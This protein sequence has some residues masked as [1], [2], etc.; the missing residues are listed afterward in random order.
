MI[1]K[2]SLSVLLLCASLAPAQAGLFDS[3]P[4]KPALSDET[5]AQIQ[6]AFDDQR[7]L[8][9]SKILDQALL[10]SG[11]DP[12]LT[13]WAGKLSLVHGRYQDALTNF[14][15]IKM[16]T[17][18]RA[19]ALEGE[20]I[21]LMQ[22]GRLDEALFSLQ[23]AVMANP[24]AWQAW[25]ALG[26]EYDRRHDWANAEN[27]YTHALSASGNA[28]IVLNNRGFSR[29]S[30]KKLDLAIPDFVAALEKKPDLA[31]ARN[32]LRLAMSMQGEYDRA[33]KGAAA[34]DQAAVL[35]NAGFAAM[36]R[37][38]YAKAKELLTQA[39][40]AKN[41]YYGLA[42]ANLEMTQNLAKT[43]AGEEG[44]ASSR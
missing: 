21:A 34:T 3:G 42:A 33:I 39:M 11:N 1:G 19:Q 22:L 38:D 15:R 14:T 12:R 35:N 18:L 40:K 8:D 10:S 24:S 44:H 25:N 37:G 6:T 41:G 23:A 31:P 5:V 32:N 43:D 17:A 29:L 7:Y 4:K 13:L 16:E 36:L 28:A 9:A 30:Q 26:S 27:A 20:G 2:K